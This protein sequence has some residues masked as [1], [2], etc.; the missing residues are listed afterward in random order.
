MSEHRTVLVDTETGEQI[1]ECPHCAE[2]EAQV[3]MLE[4]DLRAKRARIT[5][6]ERDAEAEARRHKLWDQAEAVHTWW[7]IACDHTGVAFG[8]EEFGYLLPHLKAPDRGIY[9]VLRSIAG[10]A[11]DPATKPRKNGAIKRYD[12]L[13]LITR[14]KKHLYDFA[15][16]APGLPDEHAWKRWLVTHIAS[17]LRP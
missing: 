14:T 13:E 7:A 9:L 12:D 5:N 2:L 16:R 17:S 6:L 8:A 3:T 1:T 15:S 4:R 11:Y 10:A